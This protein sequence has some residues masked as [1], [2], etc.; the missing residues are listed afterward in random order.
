MDIESLRSFLSSISLTNNQI[1]E[2][3]REYPNIIQILKENRVN[4]IDIS[5]LHRIGPYILKVI[6]R[7][8]NSNLSYTE[9]PEVFGGFIN[10][11]IAK[12]LKEKYKLL[13]EITREMNK[14]PYK[15]LC[16]L[17]GI[18]FKTAD[19][20]ILKLSKRG[21]QLDF[22]LPS[23]FMQSKDRCT[24]G[25]LFLLNQNEMSGNTNMSIALLKKTTSKIST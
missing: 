3:V 18:S 8:I 2:I 9:F 11:H 7:K 14:N 5:K 15:Y 22:N 10:L 23:N 21:N 25:I 17:D 20:I 24:Q 19:S 13:S 6:E 1:N 12:Q 4:E 16:S